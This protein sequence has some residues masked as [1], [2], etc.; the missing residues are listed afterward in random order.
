MKKSIIVIIASCFIFFNVNIV[1]AADTWT[2][3]ADFG[4][5]RAGAVGF[6]SVTRAT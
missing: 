6:S 1:F 3:K 2:Q 5:E 4:W